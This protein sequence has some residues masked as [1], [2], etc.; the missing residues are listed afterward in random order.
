M[1]CINLFSIKWWR[2][3]EFSVVKKH[4]RL[5]VLALGFQLVMCI[6]VP[7]LLIIVLVALKC[8]CGCFSSHDTD[9]SWYRLLEALIMLF[10]CCTENSIGFKSILHNNYYNYTYQWISF[11]FLSSKIYCCFV[12]FIASHRSKSHKFIFIALAMVG[13]YI[14]L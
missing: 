6:Y 9:S 2:I 13:Q 1:Y 7:N 5:V 11:A 8:P 12:C 14:Q 3:D 10:S 4:R